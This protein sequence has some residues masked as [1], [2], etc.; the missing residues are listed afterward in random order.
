ML[1]A[2][3]TLKLNQIQDLLYDVTKRETRQTFGPLSSLE[4]ILLGFYDANIPVFFF[5]FLVAA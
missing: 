3:A 1:L 4:D 5:V 2:S